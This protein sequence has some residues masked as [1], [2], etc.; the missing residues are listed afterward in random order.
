M[1][2]FLF[3]IQQ[4]QNYTDLQSA[5]SLTVTLLKYFCTF[6]TSLLHCTPKFSNARAGG[7]ELC[8]E[9]AATCFVC[10]TPVQT[11][12]RPFPFFCLCF[13]ELSAAL[14]AEFDHGAALGPCHC[15]YSHCYTNS[16]IYICSI[17]SYWPFYFK[18]PWH[19]VAFPEHD[20]HS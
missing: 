19:A 3:L 17:T 16:C 20:L 14:P 5:H 4:G 13:R 15:Y 2:F 8:C 11:V 12:K 7:L 1:L 18:Y 6:L 9:F 10:I